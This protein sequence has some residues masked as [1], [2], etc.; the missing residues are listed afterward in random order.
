MPS[1]QAAR[2]SNAK[3]HLQYPIAV[4]VGGTNG[5][6]AALALKIAEYSKNPNIHIV[7]RNATAAEK[8]LASLRSAN[9]EGVYTF[10]K[11]DVSLF[12]EVRPLTTALSQELPY[13]SHLVLSPGMLTTQGRTPVTPGGPDVK[14]TL[15]YYTRFLFLRDLTDLLV[16]GT[17]QWPSR[18][19]SKVQVMTV[20]DSKRAD[21]RSVKW[22]DLGLEKNFSLG[23]AANHCMAMN[24]LLMQRLASKHPRITFTHS[25]PSIVS[26]AIFDRPHLSPWIA[27]PSRIL[28]NTFG[29][30]PED[31]AEW[32]LAGMHRDGGDGKPRFIDSKGDDLKGKS[33]G[34]EKQ[35]EDVWR[36]SE[37]VVD[38]GAR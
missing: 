15:H 19:T 35:V 33:A 38:G 6:G 3:L 24:D 26:T 9:K 21:F 30:T 4:V 14:M 36:H 28:A 23:N 13:I 10:H 18:D 37:E 5:I 17:E 31:C 25:Y 2:A 1:L 29:S 7:G 16:K 11:C 8:V 27:T 12:S 32:F 20:L 34:T 22:D